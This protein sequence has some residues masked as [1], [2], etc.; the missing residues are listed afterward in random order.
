M[1]RTVIG[2]FALLLAAVPAQA[3]ERQAEY[4][5]N[6]NLV[7]EVARGAIQPI[8]ARV[9][10]NPLVINPPSLGQYGGELR[11]LMS[12]PKDTRL[13]VVY[14]YARLMR[15]TPSLELVPDILDHV[16]NEDDRVFT[17]HLRKGHKW[18]DGQP[19]T[20]E[21][22]R[23]WFEDVRSNEKLSPSGLP[24]ALLVDGE[25]PKFEVLSETAVR[26]SW[27]KPN[28]LFMQ[29]MAGASPL[30]IFAPAHYLKRFH[31]KYADP[32][33][34]EEMVKRGGQ[35][36][37]AA[38]H[39]KLDNMY[40]NDNPDLPTLEPWVLATR[41]PAERFIFER[42]PYFHRVDTAG[43]QLPY[44]D[45]V[46]VAVADS[47]IIPLKTGSGESDLQARYLRFD[48]YTFLKEAEE[49]NDFTV[50][51]W[52]QATGAHLAL[53]PNLNVTDPVWRELFRDVRTRRALSL[54][55]NRHEI[56]QA[57]YYGLAIPGQNTLLPASTL[58]QPEFRD[59]WAKFDLAQANQ[60]LDEVGLSKRNR[61][62]IRLLP[63]GRPM[64]IIVENSGE[65]TEQSDVL[66]LVRD[67]WRLAGIKL[68]MKPSQR[69]VFRNRVFAGETV[70]SIDKGIE[71]GLATADMPPLEFAPVTQQQLMWPK[72]GQYI[73]TKGKSGEPIALDGARKLRE[74]LGDWFGAPTRPARTE[75]WHKML[76]IWAD[77]VY[78]IG[79]VAGVLQPVVVSNRLRN[80][81]EEGIYNW[82]PGAHFGMYSPDT[83]W[84]ANA[85][86]AAVA[87]Q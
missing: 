24:Q 27:S 15:W 13:M 53:F 33:K 45:R 73:E 80:V 4:I 76:S 40:R 82:D 67:S 41:P 54:A 61:E 64:Q 3:V 49:R 57:I 56:N 62:G 18:S 29:E 7:G 59:K 58:Y 28:R 32:A 69:E 75:I 17:L 50:R 70:M 43:R 74:L 65:S 77:E 10:E 16:D 22:F 36:N 30:Y 60:L 8:E 1:I 21:D 48:N 51:L 2:A 85:A 12:S 34:L 14:G 37:W 81:P 79:L 6:P 46:S 26:Y 38:L 66:E 63:D 25:K 11:M 83:F 68:F 47:K 71:N 19:F 5:E 55:I 9:P 84:F 44:I 78:S 86:T 42:N 23:Y 31:V 87:P 39:N 20:S 52:R 35:R 72:W